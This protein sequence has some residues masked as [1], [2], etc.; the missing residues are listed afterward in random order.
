MH[1][2]QFAAGKKSEPK[3]LSRG[4]QH[5]L[6]LSAEM[7]LLFTGLQELTPGAGLFLLREGKQA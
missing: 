5:H 7:S 3:K 4:T 6:R 2:A 1:Q